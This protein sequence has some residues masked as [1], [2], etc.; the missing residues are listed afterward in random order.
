MLKLRDWIDINKIDWYNLP[1]EPTAKKSLIENKYFWY[2]LSYETNKINWNYLSSNSN[3]IELIKKDK[4]IWDTSESEIDILKKIKRNC[5]WGYL[6]A[7]PNAIVFLKDNQDNIYWPEFLK[8]PNIFTYDY[9][10]MKENMKNSGIV[11]ELMAYIFHP[12]N[13]EKWK[14]WGFTEHQEML[15]LMNE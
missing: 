11:E 8:N 7:N 1:L 6:S 5:I 13:M 4:N 15:D 2:N 3:L 14:D 12:K 9:K 10:Q